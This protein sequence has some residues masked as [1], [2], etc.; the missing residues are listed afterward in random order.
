MLR[1]NYF[2]GLSA[3]EWEARLDML[4]AAGVDPNLVGGNGALQTIS[5]KRESGF[6]IMGTVE[7]MLPADIVREAMERVSSPDRH[8]LYQRVLEKLRAVGARSAATE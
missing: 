1:H 8:I 4:L 5:I 3:E 2:G 6:L 7:N